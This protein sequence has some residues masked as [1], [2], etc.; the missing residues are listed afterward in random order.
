MGKD[1]LKTTG[2]RLLKRYPLAIFC[3]LLTWYLCLFKPP[4][5]RLDEIQNIDKVVHISMYLGTCTIL[6]IEYLRSHLR[7]QT[8][9]IILWA[10]VAPITMS[11]VIELVQEYCTTTR[12]GE[13][14]DFAANSTGV[15]L[16]AILG[17]FVLRR[18][19]H[20]KQK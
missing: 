1:F 3:I 14:A 13:W 9:K 8:R 7:E 20:P 17:H 6:W 5:T 16:A 11:G 15:L 4:R 19:I 12:S 2:L 18:H 10:I